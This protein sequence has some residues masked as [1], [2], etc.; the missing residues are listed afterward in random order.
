M[1]VPQILKIP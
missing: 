1:E